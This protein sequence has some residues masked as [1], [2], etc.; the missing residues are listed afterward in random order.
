LGHFSRDGRESMEEA[1]A[2]RGEQT[3][4]IYISADMEGVAGVVSGS[5][6]QLD[7]AEY[8]RFRHFMT[9]EVVAAIEGAK[10]AG[11]TYIMVSDSHG[12]GENILVEELPPDVEI[13]R[14]LTRPLMMM[15]GIE[16]QQFDGV[17]FIGYHASANNASGVLAHTI[18]GGLFSEI[19]LNRQSASESLINAS[20]ASH[21]GVPIIMVS[22]DDALQQ[23]LSKLQPFA[24]IEYAVTK[25][26]VGM[27]S[28]I[29]LSPHASC[30]L[31]RTKAELAVRNLPRRA[32]VFPEPPQLSIT[33]KKQIHAELLSYL[34]IV[35]R[36]GAFTISHE[37]KSY[38]EM[39][40][41]L[42]FITKYDCN[43]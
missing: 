3:L 20:I 38:L 1:R 32:F 14:G 12:K 42:R 19:L 28:A 17:I 35:K 36:T 31:I 22:G 4:R 24:D 10:K 37:P 41:F 6:C 25:R 33:F 7:G 5:Q 34:P 30:D 8:S 39:A 43:M 27:Y 11:A 2:A 16:T 18:H 26:C 23:E 15:Q 40:H 13:V 9:Q 21:F 29:S